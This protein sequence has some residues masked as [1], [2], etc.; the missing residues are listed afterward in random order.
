[1]SDNKYKFIQSNMYVILAAA[2]RAL[3]D[4]DIFDEISEDLN[5]PDNEMVEIRDHLQEYMDSPSFQ[6][7]GIVDDLDIG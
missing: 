5:I 6:Q 7:G 4:A 3:G 2:R 1:M